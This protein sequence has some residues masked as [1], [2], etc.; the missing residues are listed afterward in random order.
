MALR[1]NLD[2]Q[3]IVDEFSCEPDVAFAKRALAAETRRTAWGTYRR[4][5][6]AEMIVSSGSPVPR[7]WERDVDDARARGVECH[8]DAWRKLMARER[9]VLLCYCPTREFCHRSLLAQILTKKGAVDGGELGDDP[10]QKTLFG[11]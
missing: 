3:A 6:L 2:N 10:N 5:F 8:L 7:G 9:V 4:A 1:A 11:P